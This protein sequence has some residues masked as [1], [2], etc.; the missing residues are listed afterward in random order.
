M[1]DQVQSSVD[2]EGSSI[3]ARAQRWDRGIEGRTQGGKGARAP[4]LPETSWLSCAWGGDRDQLGGLGPLK[5]KHTAGELSIS[6][7]KSNSGAHQGL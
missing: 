6:Q 7:Y 2:G 1:T 5:E 3:H 4:Q